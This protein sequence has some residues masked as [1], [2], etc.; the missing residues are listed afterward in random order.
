MSTDTVYSECGRCKYIVSIIWEGHTCHDACDWCHTSPELFN[1]TGDETS[2]NKERGGVTWWNQCER[3]RRGYLMKQAQTRREEAWWRNQYEQGRRGVTPSLVTKRA[4]MRREEGLPPPWWQNEC[5]WGG[6]RGYPLPGANEEGGGVILLPGD[7][8]HRVEIKYI[9]GP[10]LHFFVHLV[11][12]GGSER[13][14]LQE[15]SKREL[16]GLMNEWEKGCW[17]MC[18]HKS[19]SYETNLSWN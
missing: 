1:S 6:R 3:G 9:P 10:L 15:V 2:V 8:T 18:W 14:P 16:E 17:W 5:K 13:S 12:W 7:K 11:C 19:D 4:Q